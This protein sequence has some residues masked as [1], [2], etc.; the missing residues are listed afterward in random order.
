M[1]VTMIH[2][3]KI[4]NLLLQS[5]CNV[6]FTL[7]CMIYRVEFLLIPVALLSLL[8]NHEFSMLEILWA[9]SI[10]LESVAILPQLFMV[11]KVS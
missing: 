11:S 6:L 8:V 4:K 7:A 10:Y 2:S 3:G 1:T 9:F 5:T